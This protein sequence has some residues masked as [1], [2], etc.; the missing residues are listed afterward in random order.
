[1]IVKAC[2]TLSTAVFPRPAQHLVCGFRCTLGASTYR[3][4]LVELS[5]SENGQH[6]E[7]H[8]NQDLCHEKR[9]SIRVGANSFKASTLRKDCTTA[10][11]TLR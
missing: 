11:K 3:A 2:S 1:M 10:T 4:G 7:N 6:Y 9:R 5:C 8:Q